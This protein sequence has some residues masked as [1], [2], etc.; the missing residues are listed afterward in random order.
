MRF[1]DTKADT[2]EATRALLDMLF[3]G[4]SAIFGPEGTSCNVESII[5]QARNVPMF[6]HVSIS[7]INIAQHFQAD[8]L[9]YRDYKLTQI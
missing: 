8:L 4:V 5:S 1:N 7:C 6:S 9:Y 3:E 2:V